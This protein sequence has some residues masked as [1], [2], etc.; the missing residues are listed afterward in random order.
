MERGKEMEDNENVTNTGKPSSTYKFCFNCPT[1]YSSLPWK[2]P[3]TLKLIRK[4]GKEDSTG[5]KNLTVEFVFEQS[6]SN[7][8]GL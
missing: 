2:K 5:T 3:S 8:Q 6:L 1:R 7:E 4:E